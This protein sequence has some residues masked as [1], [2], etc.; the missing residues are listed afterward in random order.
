MSR[1]ESL[2]KLAARENWCWNLVCTTCGHSVFRWGLL[3]LAGNL[4]P[5]RVDWPVRWRPSTTSAD[6]ERIN[7]PLPIG[8]WPE[9]TQS[10]IQE[11]V[12]DCNI[13]R[14]A[15]NVR[16]PD[17]LG[18]LG[19]LLCYTADVERR[20]RALTAVLVPQLM[21]DVE[22]N[23]PASQL[24]SE[25]SDSAQPLLWSDLEV[26][27]GCYSG[28]RVDREGD[29]DLLS[30]PIPFQGIA[31][32]AV[33]EY[34]GVYVI[35]D[36]D[37]VVYVGVAGRNGKGSLRSRL[38]GVSSGW[39][40]D[41]FTQHLFFAR[42]QFL[43]EPPISHPRDARAANRRY[44]EQRCFFQYLVS[45]DATELVALEERLKEELTPAFNS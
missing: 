23:S 28:P 11:A 38:R 39:F 22:P 30:N 13:E 41:M 5:V 20:N 25:I 17:W 27:E 26:I 9:A 18:H 16:F 8:P 12:V 42:V 36:L 35:R 15:Q 10:R 14:L 2:S 6:L 32:T 45:N 21:G 7:G 33:P 44:I 1:F 43:S 3:A 19:L 31:W 24:L 40:S 37:E 29:L 34:P 4:D